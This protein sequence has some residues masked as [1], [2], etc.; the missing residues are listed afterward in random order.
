MRRTKK[1]STFDGVIALLL[2]GVFAACVLLVLLTGS[3]VYRKLTVRDQE[4]YDQRTAIQYVA[5]KVRQAEL[6]SA[7]NVQDF[8]GTE[9]LTFTEYIDGEPYLTRIYCHDGWITELFAFEGGEFSPEDGERVV[10]AQALDFDLNDGLLTVDL[11]DENGQ[12]SSLTLSLRG[13]AS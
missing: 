10:E 12:D 13:E 7:I 4:A 3:D 9:A 6:G 8:D 2:F 11:T 1:Q 5:T